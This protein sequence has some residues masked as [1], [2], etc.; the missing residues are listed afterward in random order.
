[1]SK[2]CMVAWKLVGEGVGGMWI[3]GRGSMLGLGAADT[4]GFHTILL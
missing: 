2:I 1:M 3:A 4:E